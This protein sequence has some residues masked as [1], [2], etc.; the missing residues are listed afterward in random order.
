MSACTSAL[1]CLPARLR[2]M[3]AAGTV[4]IVATAA[5]TLTATPHAAAAPRPASTPQVSSR[6]LD[7]WIGRALAVMKAKHI[8][9]S[10]AG[11]LRNIKRESGGN[12][13]AVNNWDS[14]A[15]AGTPSK[16]LLQVIDPTFRS[17]HVA[18]TAWDIFDPVANIAAACNYA[19]HTYGSIDNVNSGY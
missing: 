9:G 13:R 6:V 11:I 12:P 17:F 4:A 5:L 8:P 19:A 16:G 3:S 1:T 18:G 14:N 7:Q 15:R 10:Y 2:A